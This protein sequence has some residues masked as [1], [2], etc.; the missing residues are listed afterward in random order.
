MPHGDITDRTK[1]NEVSADQ[2]GKNQSR[3]L[4]ANRREERRDS[5]REGLSRTSLVLQY[6]PCLFLSLS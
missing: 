1:D 3:F 2:V 4:E 6:L 5:V